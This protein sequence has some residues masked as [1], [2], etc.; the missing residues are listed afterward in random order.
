MTESDGRP[1][2]TRDPPAMDTPGESVVATPLSESKRAMPLRER[3]R[4]SLGLSPTQW[5]VGISV[6]LC[7]PYLLFLYLFSLPHSY[8][9]EVTM[10]ALAYSLF[11]M[12]L[13]YK[14]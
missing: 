9:L 1:D 11:A 12:Y 5:N 7:L 3:V 8:E 6:G 13:A 14:L 2:S 10:G 4:R